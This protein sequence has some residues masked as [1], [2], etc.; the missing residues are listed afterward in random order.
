[1]PAAP[2]P[3]TATSARRAG[4]R[5]LAKRDYRTLIARPLYFRHESSLRHDTGPHP[6]GPGRI[7]AIESELE[8][9]GWLGYERREAPAVAL[10]DLTAVHPRDYVDSV[11]AVSG[12]GGG[13]FGPD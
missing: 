11:R 3:T 4:V 1:M 10:E 5:S 13:A 9:R 2:A 6:E 8:A 7:P 12:A